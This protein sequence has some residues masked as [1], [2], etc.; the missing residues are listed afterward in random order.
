MIKQIINPEETIQ[1]SL[2]VNVDGVIVHYRQCK[3]FAYEFWVY[4][5]YATETEKV[6]A[7]WL[8]YS[9]K[10]AENTINKAVQALCDQS[11]DHG[12][13]WQEA[14]READFGEVSR[15]SV[16]L[17]RVTFNKNNY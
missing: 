17:V 16:Y 13:K 8:V 4:G 7:P 15:S 12:I 1:T 11:E 3:N 5:V 6:T 10:Q 2:A 14:Y 9:I